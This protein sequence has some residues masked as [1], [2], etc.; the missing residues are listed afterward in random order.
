MGAWG[1]KNFENDTAMDWVSEFNES[2]SLSFL[3]K[4]LNKAFNDEYLEADDACE[5]LATAEVLAAIKGKPGIDFPEE[6]N[7]N[8]LAIPDTGILIP[9]A[10]KAIEKILTAGESELLELWNEGNETEEWENV[11]ADLKLRLSE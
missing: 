7:S 10:I 2:P 4:T 8:S 9:K 6:I 3:E 1:I 11:L 5:I